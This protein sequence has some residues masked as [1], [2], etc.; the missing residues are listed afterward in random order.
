MRMIL[1]NQVKK[2]LRLFEQNGFQAYLVG[3]GVRDMLMGGTA[4]DYDI[5][6][7]ALPSETKALFSRALINSDGEKYG[8]LKVDTDGVRYEVTTCRRESGYADGRRPGSVEFLSD[9][10]QDLL[11]RDF[12]MNALAYNEKDGLIDLF[13]G[14][15]DIALK[16]IRCVGDPLARFSE[17]ALRI[18][19]AFRFSAQLGFTMENKTLSAMRACAGSVAYL[20]PARLRSELDKSVMAAH[21]PFPALHYTFVLT[22]FIPEIAA[23]IGFEQHTPYHNL[24]VWAH[25]VKSLEYTPEELDLKLCMLLHD[26]GKPASFTQDDKGVGHAKGHARRSA[27]MAAEIL[28][29]LEYPAKTAEHVTQLIR[30]HDRRE[31]PTYENARA[32]LYKYGKTFTRELLKIRRADNMAKNP[33]YSARLLGELDRFE[34]LMEEVIRN[35]DYITR[36]QLALGGGDLAQMGFSGAG[37]GRALS[38]LYDEVAA[39]ALPNERGALA[40]YARCALRNETEK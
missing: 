14:A 33:P 18:L 11:R 28:R 27:D 30:C 7:D 35:G 1:P 16:T 13:G 20:A 21:F 38:A 26:I 25:T 34:R 40:A 8:V 31:K 6:T 24:D 9:I 10:R 19:R 32:F 39:G 3:G 4:G 22:A 12:T 29:R 15:D 36:G 2:I 17:D 37:I 5:A 23:S